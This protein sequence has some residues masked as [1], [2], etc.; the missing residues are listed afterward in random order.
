M[1]KLKNHFNKIA[2]Q[3]I[4]VSVFY[5]VRISLVINM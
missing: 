3:K 2:I 4:V 1:K 5:T